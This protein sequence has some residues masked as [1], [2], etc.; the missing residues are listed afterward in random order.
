MTNRDELP[1]VPCGFHILVELHDAEIKTESGIILAT[2]DEAKREQTGINTATVLAFGPTCYKG[3][4]G[5]EK[6]EDW[7]VQVGDVITF[8]K[9]VGTYPNYDKYPR[10]ATIPDSGVKTIAKRVKK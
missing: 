6:P 5:C 3:F 10:L 1:Y 7:G 4:A 9:Y 8:D 2:G